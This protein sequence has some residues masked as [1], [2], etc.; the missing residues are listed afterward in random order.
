[1]FRTICQE[2]CTKCE[3]RKDLTNKE[4]FFPL[5]SHIKE[6]KYSTFVVTIISTKQST[7]VNNATFEPRHSCK[8]KKKSSAMTAVIRGLTRN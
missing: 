7:H 4:T 1:M 2:K 5:I 6:D 8:E 3:K